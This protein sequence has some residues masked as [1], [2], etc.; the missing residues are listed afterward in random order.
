MFTRFSFSIISL[1]CLSYIGTTHAQ[2]T[3]D[4]QQYESSLFTGQQ[5]TI[6][7][8]LANDGD[9]AVNW[10]AS[11][12]IVREPEGGPRRDNPGEL[13]ETIQGPY[14]TT[15]G[16]AH[17]G[18]MLWGVSYQDSRLWAIDPRSG[19]VQIDVRLGQNPIEMGFNPS[20]G[21]LYV[22]RQWGGNTIVRVDRQG[23][24]IN[25]FDLPFGGIGGIAFD[26]DGLL[27]VNH[28]DARQ[29]KQFDEANDRVVRTLNYAN[30]VGGQD[31]F[32]MQFVR[33]HERGQFWLQGPSRA[34]QINV[35]AD[36]DQG[37]AVQ[38]FATANQVQHNGL[39]HD[40]YDLW[41]GQWNDRNLFRYDDGIRERYWVRISP[42][43]GVVEANDRQAATLT[44]DA[45][46][47]PGGDYEA[48]ITF[49][50][51]DRENPEIVFS[52]LLHVDAAADIEVVWGE[53]AGYPNGID[54][55]R[56]PRFEDL[57]VGGVYPVVVT[58][59]NHGVEALEI[60]R[61]VV[62]NEHFSTSHDQL[63]VDSGTSSE[64]EVLFQPQESGEVEAVLEMF[65]NDPDAEEVRI[66]LHAV[67]SQPPVIVVDP[68]AIADELS[69]GERSEHIIN[70]ANSGDAPLRWGFE[71]D[72]TAAPDQDALGRNLRHA[73]GAVHA[74]SRASIRS[75][76]PRRDDPGEVLRRF[77]APRIDPTGMAWDDSRGW[78]WMVGFDQQRIYALEP[79]TGEVLVD[80]ASNFYCIGL[81][82]DPVTSQIIASDVNAGQIRRFDIEGQLVASV[83]YPQG[84][85]IVGQ[86]YDPRSDRFWTMDIS[87]RLLIE[88]D[89]D[90]QII[91]SVNYTPAFGPR[92]GEGDIEFVPAHRGGNIWVTTIRQMY[93]LHVPEGALEAELISSFDTDI[94]EW[95]HG[96]AHDGRD[97]WLS[98]RWGSQEVVV[99]DDGFVEYYWLDVEPLSGME[100]AG[101]DANVVLTLSA[102]ELLGGRYEALLRIR[103]ND[104]QTP[105]VD[106]PVILD[107][108]GV[109][110][111]EVAWPG[112]LG[113]PNELNF[114]AA[115]RDLFTNYEFA[116]TIVIS[117]RGTADLEIDEIVSDNEY[118]AADPQALAIPHHQSAEVIIGFRPGEDGEHV[119]RI[120]IINNDPDERDVEI[121]AVGRSESPPVMEIDPQAFEEELM[122]D[123]QM[124]RSLTL[125]NAGGADLRWVGDIEFISAPERDGAGRWLRPGEPGGPLRPRRDDPGDVLRRFNVARIGAAGLAWDDGRGWMWVVGFDQQRIYAYNPANGQVPVDFASNFYCIGLGYDPVERRIIASDVNAR[126]IRVFNS[127]GQL[128]RS[129]AYPD[130]AYI[131]GQGYD[132]Q[133]DLFWTG[134]I[135]RR[136]LLAWN[137]DWEVVRTVSYAP[138]F[139]QRGGEGD[140]EF[141]PAHR[142][143]PIWVTT[144]GRAYQLAIPEDANEARL[145][146]SFNTDIRE[147]HHGM[148][149]DGRDVWISGAWGAPEVEIIDDGIVEYYW[150]D[151]DPFRGTLASEQAQEVSVSID[152]TDLIEGLYEA[153]L[154]FSSNDPANPRI[155]VAVSLEVTG[156]PELQVSW[157]E[158]LGFPNEIDFNRA[159]RDLFTDFRYEAQFVVANEGTALLIVE[160][161]TSDNEYFTVDPASF[162]VAHHQEQVVTIILESEE[163]GEHRGT[164]TIS[165][166]DPDD[167]EFSIEVRA[168][169][170]A[171]PQLA[172]DPEAIEVDFLPGDVENRRISVGNEGIAELRWNAAIE[173]IEAP[174]RDGAERRLRPAEPG[175]PLRPRRDNPGEVLRRFDAPRVNPTGMEWD[176]AQSWMWMTAFD[177]QRIYALDPESGDVQVEFASNFY[178]IGLGFDPLHSLIIASDVNARFIRIFNIRGDLVRSI[179]YPDGAYI[180]GQG[181]DP[182]TDRF[183]SMDISRRLLIEWNRDWQILRNVNYTPAFQPRGGE[184]DMVF[185]PAHQGGHIW[186]TTIRRAYR[187]NVPEGAVEASL[188]SDFETDIQEWHHGLAHD[189]QNLWLSGRW[190]SPEVEVID[191]GIWEQY[192]LD[193]SPTSGT[194]PG[195]EREFI[196]LD[197]DATDL[198]LGR[199]VAALNFATNDPQRPDAAVNIVMNVVED[200]RPRHLLRL[201]DATIDDN[202]IPDG[203][204]VGVLTPQGE[205]AGE[206]V[207]IGDA[208]PLDFFAWGA[209][210]GNAGF[211][212]GDPFDFRYWDEDAGREYVALPNIAAGPEEFT[213]DAIST[214]SLAAVSQRTMRIDL[215]EGWNTISIN[216]VPDR[217]L[218]RR[219]E[220]PDIVLMT[221]RLRTDPD[222]LESAHHILLLKDERGRFYNPRF[223][224]NNIP[225]WNLTEGY[226]VK[227]DQAL[228]VQWTGEPIPADANIPVAT[229]WNF[230]AY[231]PTYPLPCRSPD[232][233]AVSSILDHVLLIKDARGRFANPR[234][235]FSNMID[236]VEGQGYQIKVDADVVLNYPPEPERVALAASEPKVELVGW[237]EPAPTGGNM[238]LLIT[239]ITGS[240]GVSDQVGALALSGQ[241]VG[242]GN[243]LEG[244]MAGL[245]VWGDDPST[246]AVDGLRHGESFTLGIW[247][248]GDP[249]PLPLNVEAIIEGKS[250]RYEMDSFTALQATIGS[251]PK[252][253]ELLAAYPNPFNSSTRFTFSLPEA[254]L[255]K[256]G[257]YDISGR[258]VQS[259]TRHFNAGTHSVGWNADGIPAGTYFLKAEAGS[260]VHTQKLLLVK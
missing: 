46:A 201:T 62:E 211:S 199:Y 114:N 167:E 259:G 104:P 74:V 249:S 244:G 81:G 4:P 203:W 168:A 187:L 23:Q 254:G 238:S 22:S 97:L 80:F 142:N 208:A 67:S 134:D 171:Q 129:I 35:P 107:V 235:R 47:L 115:F 229:G 39:T 256:V 69:T 19:E 108:I 209:D 64:F 17:D 119:A 60:G 162:E 71:W 240:V 36:G 217:Q 165:C 113:F 200:L 121:L 52:V 9:E 109:P 164:L 24:Q 33:A 230:I 236:M 145:I 181:Y 117:N 32:C 95:H 157:S 183:W 158:D 125:R 192:W 91:R 161:I 141:V 92:G 242:L 53:A 219:D 210:E 257:I 98:G 170:L 103:S 213:P 57:F 231:F 214:L 223:G 66:D 18:E 15:S 72:Y 130:G 252:Q 245:A 190:G 54:W 89:R 185:V 63:S 73:D 218:Y 177:Q 150:L 196:T 194:L 195:G 206:I 146:S 78:M 3:I 139:E 143:G 7:V 79:S 29:I 90:W 153:E 2:F 176:P 251:I 55:T 180:V 61:I 20:D 227:V 250:L 14:N 186:V 255:M 45:F 59:F 86:G 13:L 65:T 85:Y 133:G 246:E 175:G 27:W 84:A 42:D 182:R 1:L 41:V 216:V 44:L 76:G 247:R 106:V 110:D 152:A 100:D 179:Q 88:W 116:L 30:A 127:D 68:Q 112:E 191:D 120:T 138:A 258:E 77:N 197:F 118:F 173:F 40:G 34:F 26:D 178:C 111:I 31:C 239:G 136:L 83:R 144:I 234:F 124:A 151:I 189:R 49:E 221:D 155:D 202:V 122:T 204:T 28:R 48:D 16:L 163:D 156:I 160:S 123:E 188:V 5:E 75:P 8:T 25:Q 135:S 70:I 43:R 56:D 207:W 96:L 132:P 224:F 50:S 149:H 237:H 87:R 222:D 253:F 128:I 184:G 166:N 82:Y 58:V 12:R 193:F 226:Q 225:Y 21:L 215:A 93:R 220:G 148:A 99:V 131:V 169:T 205:L 102:A 101:E 140:I 105:V 248:R 126:Q 174:E 38:N 94:Q 228:G 10:R 172:I 154:R 51:N 241:L 243:V 232:F 233:Y 37:E 137:R 147:W 198:V 260:A 11:T 159:Y 6:E 212:P